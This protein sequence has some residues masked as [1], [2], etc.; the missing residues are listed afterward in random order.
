MQNKNFKNRPLSYFYYFYPAITMYAV[1]IKVMNTCT[2]NCVLFID[3]D[4]RSDLGGKKIF[5]SKIISV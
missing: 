1:D 4:S 3:N 2:E 5:M